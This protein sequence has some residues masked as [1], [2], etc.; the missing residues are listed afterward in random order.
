MNVKQTIISFFVAAIVIWLISTGMAILGDM[1]DTAV[2]D[3]RAGF[4]QGFL[5]K[6]FLPAIAVVA[7]SVGWLNSASAQYF[8]NHKIMTEKPALAVIIIAIIYLLAFGSIMGASNIFDAYIRSLPTATEHT[9]L[10][11]GG[12]FALYWV[13]LLVNPSSIVEFFKSVSSKEKSE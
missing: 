5:I 8:R 10:S 3:A 7:F 4:L 1:K 9:G 6:D 11:F 12:F 13:G 2:F